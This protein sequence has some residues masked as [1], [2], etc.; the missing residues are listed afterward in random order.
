VSRDDVA[1]ARCNG[2]ARC[3]SGASWGK[4]IVD[5]VGGADA[6]ASRDHE[7]VSKRIK[8]DDVCTAIQG[9]LILVV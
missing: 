2:Q 8:L 9:F 6:E 7:L 4:E 5:E 1:A 3:S